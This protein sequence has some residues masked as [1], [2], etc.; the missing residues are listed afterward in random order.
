VRFDEFPDA[1]ILEFLRDLRLI[2]PQ[3]REFPERLMS[4]GYVIVDPDL[5]HSM[6]FVG[7]ERFRGH[8]IHCVRCHERLD[9][10]EIGIGRA[11]SMFSVHSQ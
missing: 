4:A 9:I 6:L 1:F 5:R 11:L 3:L 10:I 7:L 2:N 8:G